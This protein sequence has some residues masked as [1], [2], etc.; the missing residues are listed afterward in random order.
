M[1]MEKRP[2]DDQGGSVLAVTV[3]AL[4]ILGVVS[5]SFVALANLE[6]RIGV[7]HRDGL[8]VLALAQSGIHIAKD[9]IRSGGAA[10]SFDTWVNNLNDAGLLVNAFTL[11]GG[12]LSVRI[13]NDCHANVLG[14]VA[15]DPGCATNQD[16]NEKVVLTAWATRGKGRARV[17][18][19]MTS[20]NAWKHS[21]YNA[22]MILCTQEPSANPGATLIPA[23]PDHENGPAVGPL[24]LPNNLQCGTDVKTPPGIVLAATD[25]VIQPYY[26]WALDDSCTAAMGCATTT[27]PCNSLGAAAG[28]WNGTCQG[29][30]AN[31][32]VFY[33][34]PANRMRGADVQLGTGGSA[35]LQCVGDHRNDI[36]AGGPT[37]DDANGA[38]HPAGTTCGD[39][40]TNSGHT[41]YVMGK[42]TMGNNTEVNGTIVI[43]GN[44]TAGAG[45]NLDLAFTGTNA[46]FAMPTAC[47]KCGPGLA[48]VMYDPVPGPVPPAPPHTLLAD[49]SNASGDMRI[50]G[51]V[52][53]S[54]TVEF[55][56]ILINGGVLAYTSYLH[57]PNSGI[58]YNDV[59]GSLAPPPGF[60]PAGTAGVVM[61][62]RTFG[63]CTYADESAVGTAP[64]TCP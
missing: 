58:T 2:L 37:H 17:R 39:H 35:E 31:G 25:C 14:S 22:D 15:P 23:E 55:N 3:I 8:G 38:D 46:I 24:P 20:T 21:C 51:I 13:D 49:I 52:Y 40:S 63:H 34:G 56:P 26:D 64:K 36:Y 16:R 50:N 54:G 60:P 42:L 57:T 45:P 43:H 27:T 5:F 19:W 10:G 48:I 4:L 33:G 1:R 6:M 47:A 61:M 29:V 28:S 53:S 18:I 32:L 9:V 44:G 59:F 62:R 12:T 41:L 7:N 11:E 30:N